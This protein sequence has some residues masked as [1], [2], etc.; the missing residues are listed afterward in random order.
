[1][2]RSLFGISKIICSEQAQN[3]DFKISFPT[4]N[5]HK[6]EQNLLGLLGNM[7]KMNFWHYVG[8]SSEKKK[9]KLCYENLDAKCDTLSR[10]IQNELQEKLQEI[11]QTMVTK[12]QPCYNSREL[13]KCWK[14][15]KE[16]LCDV[17]LDA[18][19]QLWIDAVQDSIDQHHHEF[20]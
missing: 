15:S 3:S 5:H 14:Q 1:M 4:Y 12:I 19:W 20:P 11:T 9:T 16:P 7:V 10:E 18:E 13:W 17:D 8:E 6:V 2:L